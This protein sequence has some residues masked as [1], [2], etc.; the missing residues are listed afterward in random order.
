MIYLINKKF[1]LKSEDEIGIP[2]RKSQS[3]CPGVK[4]AKQINICPLANHHVPG[5]LY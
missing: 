4:K 5:E 2:K 1:D 3:E